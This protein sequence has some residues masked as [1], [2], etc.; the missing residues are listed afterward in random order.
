M[1]QSYAAAGSLT[2]AESLNLRRK[3]ALALAI[4]RNKSDSR[5]GRQH[6]QYLAR[7][8]QARNDQKR[9]RVASI[10]QLLHLE[11]QNN[12]MLKLALRSQMQLQCHAESS[13][14]DNIDNGSVHSENTLLFP[15]NF[16]E[17]IDSGADNLTQAQSYKQDA[18]FISKGIRNVSPAKFLIVAV[19]RFPSNGCCAYVNLDKI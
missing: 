6:A 10:Q 5:T 14:D 4:I 7:F 1:S 3:V 11:K 13:P 15:L 8:Y 2:D 17:D 12:T 16:V 9:M 18:V 19:T